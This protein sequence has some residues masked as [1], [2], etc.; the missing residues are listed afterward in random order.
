MRIKAERRNIQ[1]R[2]DLKKGQKEEQR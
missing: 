1:Q 2:T